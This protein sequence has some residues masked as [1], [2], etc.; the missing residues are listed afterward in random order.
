MSNYKRLRQFKLEEIFLNEEE[1]RIVLKFIFESRDHKSID[2]LPMNDSLR[3]FAQGL[4]LEA[5]DASYAVGYID[6]M[7]RSTANPTQGAIKV[8][9][10]FGKKAAKHWFKHASGDDL[11][12]AKIYDFIRNRI[13][14]GFR[15]TLIGF[16]AN[17]ELEKQAGAFIAYK[18]PSIDH[19]KIWG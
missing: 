16:F 17:I 18:I 13:A 12:D 1:A 11:L 5:V 7:F 14:I 2:S 10:K 4:L 8:I 15:S 6:A 3:E 19:I 9:K